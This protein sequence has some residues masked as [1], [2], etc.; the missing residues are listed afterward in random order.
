VRV[1]G[2]KAEGVAFAGGDELRAGDAEGGVGAGV[3]EVPGEL[4]AGDFD[5][6]G[7][8]GGSGVAGC[9]PEAFGF[10]GERREEE[11]ESGEGEVFDAP[12]VLLRWVAAG[13]E[14]EEEDQVG[15]GDESEGDPEV[16]EEMVVEGGAVS[17]GVGG[18]PEGRLC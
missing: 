8:E 4:D 6:E 13:E 3:A 5:L 7:R 2:V 14:T 12:E 17:A 15:E 18:E 11:G 10:D 9:G 16:E 1:G